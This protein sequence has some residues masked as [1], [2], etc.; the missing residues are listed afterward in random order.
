[1]NEAL[2]YATGAAL[3]VLGTALILHLAKERGLATGVVGWTR[4]FALAAGAATGAYLV[5]KLA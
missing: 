4:T 2:K 1:M 3:G 5:S